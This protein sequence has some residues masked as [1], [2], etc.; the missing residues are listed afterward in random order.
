MAG[1]CARVGGWHIVSGGIKEAGANTVVKA[2]TGAMEEVHA[3]PG[4]GKC[5][6]GEF[7]SLANSLQRV[8]ILQLPIRGG[9]PRKSFLEHLGCDRRGFNC[10]Y[11]N[12]WAEVNGQRA[13]HTAQGG[14]ARSV[15]DKVLLGQPCVN[16]AD[17][18][19]AAPCGFQL[20]EEGLC[21]EEGGEEVHI[22]G[23]MPV[24]ARE[25]F[26]TAEDLDGR[27]VDQGV[28][29]TPIETATDCAEDGVGIGFIGNDAPGRMRGTLSPALKFW[30]PQTI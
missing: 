7:R 30:A 13:G 16:A 11:A 28:E 2:H 27:V 15:G 22:E 4:D 24:D 19:D 21:E 3:T 12:A 8:A 26:R 10:V 1:I 17:I 20:G 18:E 9:F 6:F 14:L 23:A 5:Q 25:R 29:A